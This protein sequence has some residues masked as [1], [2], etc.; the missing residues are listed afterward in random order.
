MAPRPTSF[1][2]RAA[3]RAW[4]SQH[5]DSV[6]ELILRCFK[7]AHAAAGVTYVEA[8][9][10]ALCFGWIDGVRRP[11]DA[12]SFSQRFTPRKPKSAWSRV[13]V[14]KF[15]ALKKAGLIEPP[16]QAAFDRGTKTAY[17]YESR[18][19]RL[20]PAFVK[21]LKD[22]PQAGPFFAAQPP[23]YRRLLAFYMMSAKQQETRERR[24]Q[25][26]MKFA[27]QGKRIP[28]NAKDRT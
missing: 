20:D 2:N 27:R 10:E 5:H 22:D 24:F 23:G 12:R 28:L 3:F 26:L 15:A 21:R 16:G 18:P 19:R 9:D 4:L 8:L 7:V 6:D 25:L 17:N 1:A 13:N 11:L 14:G